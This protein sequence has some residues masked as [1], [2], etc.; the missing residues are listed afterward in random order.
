MRSA[1]LPLH[2]AARAARDRRTGQLG[3]LVLQAMRAVLADRSCPARQAAMVGNSSRTRRSIPLPSLSRPRRLANPW[4]DVAADVFEGLDPVE[5]F[6]TAKLNQNCPQ[7]AVSILGEGLD[8]LQRLK[9]RNIGPSETG[10]RCKV[11]EEQGEQTQRIQCPSLC[12][13]RL[14]P[15]ALLLVHDRTGTCLLGLSRRL[16]CRGPRPRPIVPA[17][18]RYPV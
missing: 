8:R 13:P 16:L 17:M 15:S 9:I 4:A 3:P 7:T 18:A 1:R 14:A 10:Q 5:P 2:S 12:F 6:T 11:E